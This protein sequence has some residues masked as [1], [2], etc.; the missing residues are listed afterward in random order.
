SNA[1]PAELRDHLYFAVALSNRKVA[2]AA[3][4]VSIAVQRYD[5]FRY[6]KVFL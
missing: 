4:H 5:Y 6:C 1:L 2:C 3:Y